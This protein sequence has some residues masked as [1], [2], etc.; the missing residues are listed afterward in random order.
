VPEKDVSFNPEFD[1]DAKPSFAASELVEEEV[2][3]A[4]EVEAVPSPEPEEDVDDELGSIFDNLSDDMSDDD[5]MAFMDDLLGEDATFVPEKDVS[6]NPEFDMDATPSY[7]TAKSTSSPVEEPGTDMS[8]PELGE[9]PDDPDDAVAWLEDLAATQ[10]DVDEDEWREDRRTLGLTGLLPSLD[11]SALPE[12][13]LDNTLEGATAVDSSLEFDETLSD[14]LPDWL[15][16]EEE[17]RMPGHT[18][19]LRSLPEPDVAGW[20]EAEQEAMASGIFEDITTREFNVDASIFEEDAT[21][22]EA[23]E[24]PFEDDFLE[25]RIATGGLFSIDENV[26]DSARQALAKQDYKSALSNYRQL[27]HAGQGLSTLI[28][29]LETAADEHKKPSLR[30]LLGDAYMRN[31]QLNR[32]LETYREALDGL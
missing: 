20:L 17:E 21:F 4:V 25:E 10:E 27:V 6:F 24:E 29:E 5:I 13:L 23:E 15:G 7:V 14:S 8:P 2:E 19:W 12:D 26:L 31:G 3:T 1:M 9:L 16:F 22:L 11:D 18:D 30:H 32:A 28:A